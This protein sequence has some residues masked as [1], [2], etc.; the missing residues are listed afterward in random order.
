MF[1]QSEVVIFFAFLIL[2]ITPLFTWVRPVDAAAN[3][4]VAPSGNDDGP[5]TEILPWATIQKAAN[6]LTAGDTVYVR[7][8]TYP[9]RLIISHSG[10]SADGT[11]TYTNYP[12]EVPILDGTGINLTPSAGLIDV[13]NIAYINLSG[14]N[15]INSNDAAIYVRNS[16]H[17]NILNNHTLNSHSSGIGVWSSDQVVVDHNTIVN[18]HILSE[19]NGGHEESLSVASTTN[20]EVSYND[21]SMNGQASYL[22]NEGIDVKE[23]S[24]FGKVHH[25][26]IHDFQGNG[27]ALYVDAWTAVTPSLSNIDIYNNYLKNTYNG[28]NIGSEQGGTAENIN[29]FNNLVYHTGSVGIGVPGRVGDGLRKNINIFNNTIF[30][31]QYNGG[32]GIYLTSANIENI[33]IRNN[34]VSLN[35]TNGEITAASNALLPQVTCDHNLVFGSKSC[36]QTYPDC[37]EISNNPVGYPRIYGNITADPQ[38]VG[39]STLPD[40]HLSATSPAIN[41]GADLVS[42]GLTFD[43]DG[44]VRPQG[45]AFDIGAFEYWDHT[46][47]L[48]GDFN[49]DHFVDYQDLSQ[50]L[51]HFDTQNQ[52]YNLLNTSLID[53]FDFNH[54]LIH[55]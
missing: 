26:Y 6:T 8:G 33:V 7:A 1:H 23:A 13:R 2:I 43:Y 53:I 47:S 42:F 30:S 49:R 16:Q 4:Y 27:G 25:N 35:Y 22:G 51:P 20:F 18:A 55:L 50:F 39:N 5:G 14:F 24:R 10:S 38:F 44:V 3:Y 54:F 11:I 41:A 17:V 52:T 29:V 19:A 15:V 21:I 36:S 45:N 40:L 28:I 32:A 48:P 31:A 37:V 46:T 12:N 9:T 34:L